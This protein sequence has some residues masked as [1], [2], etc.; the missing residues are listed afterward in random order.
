MEYWLVI[1]LFNF[2]WEN[3]KRL[4]DLILIEQTKINHS[5]C[6]QKWVWYI[7]PLKIHSL[8]SKVL[9][10]GNKKKKQI[11]TIVVTEI[12]GYI[13]TSYFLHSLS[14][15]YFERYGMVLWNGPVCP[16][17]HPSVCP[18]VRLFT[19]ACERDILKTACQIDSTF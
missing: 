6:T 12:H 9:L 7:F 8:S 18:S 10:I 19:M 11:L 16:S 1:L 2:Y 5:E 13:S 4:F 17:V 14:K 3:I 15:R